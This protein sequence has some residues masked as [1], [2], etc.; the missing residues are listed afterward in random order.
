MLFSTPQRAALISVASNTLL[1][2]AKIAVAF[3]SGSA[4]LLSE[5]LHSGLD[6]MASLIAWLSLRFAAHPPDR[7]HP[8]GHGK[9]ENIS[10]F[11]E[12][13]LI[14]GVAVWVLYEAGQRLFTPVALTHLHLAMGVL[15]GSAL[16]NLL[17]SYALRRAAKRFDSVALEADAAHL[18]TDVYTS[19]GALGGLAGY[20]FTGYHLFDTGTALAVG[21]II[22]GIGLRVSHG[23]LHG[24]LDS[25]LPA[26][27]EETVREI[28]SQA[29]P[30]L[31]LK[32]I[33]S[34]KAGP[35]RYLDLT[36]TVCRWETLEE[37]HRLCDDLEG[38]IAARFPGARIFIHPEPCLLRR[39]KQDAETCACPL[40]LNI[41]YP[42]KE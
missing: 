6:L 38:R 15:G 42:I 29:T 26:Q 2:A 20:Y 39:D 31:A 4:A 37:I 10:A 23:A 28:I 19:V 8:Y 36:L 24:L 14:I 1:V 16:V 9:W 34:R 21:A 33:V 40:Q 35:M 13:L 12:G 22:F 5:A 3:L 27:E 17:V 30:H 32:E 18:S 41:S 7:E 11:L 25:R